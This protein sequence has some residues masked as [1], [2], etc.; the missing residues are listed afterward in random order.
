MVVSDDVSE[1]A[2]QEHVPERWRFTGVDQ[3]YDP[4]ADVD[5]NGTTFRY[6]PGDLTIA[7]GHGSSREGVVYLVQ[8]RQYEKELLNQ[9]MAEVNRFSEAVALALEFVKIL[10]EFIEGEESP[11]DL[12]E[13]ARFVAR[14]HDELEERYL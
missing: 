7:V 4:H 6:E 9:R 13:L 8:L 14:H 11:R 2:V 10:D 3:M 12:K 1:S 5:M